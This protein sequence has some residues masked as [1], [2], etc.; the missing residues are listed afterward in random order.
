MD[1]GL[2]GKTAVVL[3]ASAGIGRGIATVLAQEGCNL[4]ICARN[5]SRVESTASVIRSETG[6]SVFSTTAD[7]S[8]PA[9]LD[10]FFD[11]VF[12]S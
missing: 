10:A 12:E 4:A 11:D 5:E 2:T 9:S 8:D 7:V 3:A 1:L 6:V